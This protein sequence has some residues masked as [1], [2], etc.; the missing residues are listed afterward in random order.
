MKNHIRAAAL[1]GASLA[2]VFI[3]AP[4]AILPARAVEGP[5]PGLWKMIIKLSL[6]GAKPV[7]RTA[8]TCITPEQAKKQRDGDG[9]PAASAQQNCKRLNFQRTASGMTMRYRCA[10]QVPMDMTMTYAYDNPQRY[11]VAMVSTGTRN[12]TAFK[13]STDIDA[14]RLGECPK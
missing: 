2:F 3:L 1:A 12:G 7:T 11:K 5:Q 9:G 14:R 8:D 6:P 4:L 10:G 13:S